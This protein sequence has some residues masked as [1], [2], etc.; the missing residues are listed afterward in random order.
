MNKT[1]DKYVFKPVKFFAMAYLF[2][3]TFWIPAIFVPGSAGAG[4]MFIGLLAPGVVSTVFV[5]ASGSPELKKDLKNKIIGFYK[6]KWINVFL[7]IG[8]FA[9]FR[10]SPMVVYRRSIVF[11]R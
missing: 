2:T 3:W 5:L 6:V 9:M 1:N 11:S 8:V 10:V 7:G 4:L